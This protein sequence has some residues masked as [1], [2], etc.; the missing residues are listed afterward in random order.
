[1]NASTRKAIATIQAFYANVPRARVAAAQAA[2][3][4]PVAAAAL[5]GLLE[6]PDRAAAQAAAQARIEDYRCLGRR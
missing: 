6:A 2:T 5:A 1:M 3:T 4:D